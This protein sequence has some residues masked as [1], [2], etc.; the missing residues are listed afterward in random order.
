M[1]DGFM[2]DEADGFMLDEAMTD[3]SKKRA[4]ANIKFCAHLFLR[5]MLSSGLAIFV[6][7][8]LLH[9]MIYDGRN[10]TGIPPSSYKID[11]VLTLFLECGY[12]LEAQVNRVRAQINRPKM[13]A[14]I[15][16]ELARLQCAK[17]EHGEPLA[18]KGTRS[19]IENLLDLREN[20]WRRKVPMQGSSGDVVYVEEVVGARPD[21]D[22]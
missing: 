4:I 14:D 11:C 17:D 18:D 10:M 7:K 1:L 15:F 22:Y 6:I 3:R 5:E 21:Y 9:P 20:G 16:K 19:A 2:L 8:K 13:M 12:A